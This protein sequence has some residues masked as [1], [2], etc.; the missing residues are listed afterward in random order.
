MFPGD[1]LDVVLAP[2]GVV[3][4]GWVFAGVANRHDGHESVL[5]VM[6]AMVSKSV[7]HLFYFFLN[8]FE[9]V[10]GCFDDVHSKKDRHLC[11]FCEVVDFALRNFK[12]A[13]SQ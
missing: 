7:A 12:D 3:V 13:L 8:F 1:T 11:E 4:L 10:F 5:C 6:V 9:D 2:V